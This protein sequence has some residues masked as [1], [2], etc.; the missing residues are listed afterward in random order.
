MDT[1]YARICFTEFHRFP[2][3]LMSLS[4]REKGMVH[5]FIHEYLDEKEKQSKKLKSKPTASGGQPKPARKA[6]R[7]RR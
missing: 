5:A 6:R 4:D 7:G 2:G 1:W 3:E